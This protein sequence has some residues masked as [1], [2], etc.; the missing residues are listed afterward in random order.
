MTTIHSRMILTYTYRRK[1]LVISAPPVKD[2]L[3]RWPGL[4]L[5]SDLSAEFSRLANLHLETTFVSSFDKYLEKLLELLKQ[6]KGASRPKI[7]SELEILEDINLKRTAVLRCLPLYFNEH[8][9]YKDC[10]DMSGATVDG[11]V[12]QKI[13]IS[14]EDRKS[15]SII[16]DGNVVMED[17]DNVPRS[18]AMYFCLH[19]CL[20]LEYAKTHGR[21]MEFIQKV[22]IN[23]DGK[24]LSPK[25]Q[26]LKTKLMV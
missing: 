11:S 15:I 12:S 21:T 1:E 26:N 14:G 13:L 16:I 8:P 18:L 23:L 4:F 20:H 10:Q 17:I 2:I 19:Y 24:K 5:E 9:F 3:E 6:R 22:L 7:Q 25:V